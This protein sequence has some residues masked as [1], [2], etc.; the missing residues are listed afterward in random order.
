MSSLDSSEDKKSIP[1]LEVVRMMSK[2]I[3]DKP[4]GPNYSD[5]SKTICLYLR[6]IHM[7]NHLQK[8]HPIDDS[9]DEWLED[10]ARLFLQIHNSTDGKVFTLINHCEFVKRNN[11]IFRVCVFWQ[12]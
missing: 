7:A 1:M 6:S 8:D 2:I 11:G 3:E 4:T 10:D 9:K 12:R 5:W